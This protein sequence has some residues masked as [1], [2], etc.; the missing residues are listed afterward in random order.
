MD[1]FCSANIKTSKF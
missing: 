1:Q